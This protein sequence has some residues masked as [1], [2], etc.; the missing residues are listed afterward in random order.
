MSD[1][2]MTI[3]YLAQ[4][5]EEELIRLSER[6][7]PA[8]KG[9]L[10]KHFSR[11]SPQP[12][13]RTIVPAPFVSGFHEEAEYAPP[14]PSAPLLS[15]RELLTVLP[16]V[17]PNARRWLKATDEAARTA[18]SQQRVLQSMGRHVVRTEQRRD[19]AE[20]RAHELHRLAEHQAAALLASA[21]RCASIR[22]AFEQQRAQLWH[23]QER[24][25][26]LERGLR[27]VAR[28]RDMALA[29]SAAASTT[30]RNHRDPG[31]SESHN[32]SHNTHSQ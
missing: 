16:A 17:V 2:M 11:A 18:V 22:E 25:K 3:S 27:M 19:A 32:G 1:A 28:Q 26:K 10:S 6:L 12:T 8:V 20:Q 14:P 13:P 4:M 15:H 31:G 30:A 24:T 23:E 29:A 7:S 9:R 5:P 21:A